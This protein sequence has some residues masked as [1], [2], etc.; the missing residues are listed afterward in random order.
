MAEG[1]PSGLATFDPIYLLSVLIL[2][3]FL[4]KGVGI[5]FGPDVTRRWCE[6]NGV[7]G[8]LRSHEVRQDGYAIEHDGLCTTVFSAPNYCDQVGNKGAYVCLLFFFLVSMRALPVLS[9][10]R[11]R[12]VLIRRVKGSITSLMHGRIRHYVL[13]RITNLGLVGQGG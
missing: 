4:F 3:C 8:I 1:H 7:T 6:L 9:C 10:L 12:F 5:G 13:W 2:V 11:N